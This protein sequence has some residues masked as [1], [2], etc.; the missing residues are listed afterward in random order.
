MVEIKSDVAASEANKERDDPKIRRRRKSRPRNAM[1]KR[2]MRPDFETYNRVHS[3]NMKSAAE[4]EELEKIPKFKARPLNK[5]E[6]HN[7]RRHLDIVERQVT[8]VF[9]RFLHSIME[10]QG[11]LIVAASLQII[12]GFSQVAIIRS[13]ATGSKVF[14]VTDLDKGSLDILVTL[15][16]TP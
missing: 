13:S 4:F 16:L 1:T 14:E 12:L 11:V 3:Y 2:P 5:K 9:W 15:E 6:N 7:R 10:T 8:T